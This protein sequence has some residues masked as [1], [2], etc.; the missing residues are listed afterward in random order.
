MRFR[1]SISLTVATVATLAVLIGLGS[2]QL[3]RRAWKLELVE[4][5][6]A[7]MTEKA[8]TLPPAAIAPEAWRFRR[9]LVTGRFDHRGEAHLVSHAEGGRIGYRVLTP[10]VRSGG[11]V[12]MVDRGWVPEELKD[13]ALRAKGLLAGEV[14]VTGIARVAA[15]QGWFVPDND[16]AANIWFFTDLAAM[17]AAAGYETVQP[18]YVV[19]ETAPVTW[20]RAERPELSLRNEH[21]QY[22]MTWYGLAVVLAVI[23]FLL[24]LRRGREEGAG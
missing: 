6:E 5:V 23:Y 9:V 24:G 11:G 21:L 10:L 20:P 2:W 16:P 14:T 13:P 17:G 12:V 8:V 4:A 3:E 22:A 19:A 1:P 18:V 15:E 7:R